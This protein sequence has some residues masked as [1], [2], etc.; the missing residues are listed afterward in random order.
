MEN[1]VTCSDSCKNTKTTSGPWITE[2]G[3]WKLYL[4]IRHE[5]QWVCKEKNCLL[6]CFVC[7]FDFDKDDLSPTRPK[8]CS[9]MVQTPTKANKWTKIVSS[10]SR[11]TTTWTN[12]VITSLRRDQRDVQHWH[13]HQ[14]KL[15]RETR[16]RDLGIVPQKIRYIN[17]PQLWWMDFI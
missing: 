11:I 10:I 8:G 13:K 2:P 12:G 16:G 7:N 1:R 6:R 9:T 17:I 15:T 14:P 5:R 4:I 3:H